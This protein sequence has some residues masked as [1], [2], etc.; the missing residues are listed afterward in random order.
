MAARKRLGLIFTV[1]RKWMG[2]T[3]YVLN[4]IYALSTLPDAEK[5]EI[6][7]LCKSEEDYRLAVEYT[8]YPYLSFRKSQKKM[9]TLS[10]ALNKLSRVIFHRNLIPVLRNVRGLDY[11]FP[12]IGPHQIVK[13][14]KNIAW[15]PDFQ[16]IRLPHLFSEKEI[17]HRDRVNNTL[18]NKNLPI[19]FSS[20]DAKHD[21]C[22]S[23][24]CDADNPN[25]FLYRFASKP[26]VI[27]PAADEVLQKYGVQAGGYFI[28]SNQF[29]VH[30]NHAVLFEAVKIL[31]ER[32]LKIKLLCTGNN[33]DYRSREHYS[34]LEEFVNKNGLQDSIKLLGLIDRNEQL[35]L[36]ARSRAVIQPSLFEG[37]NTSVEEAKSLNKLLILSDLAVHKEQCLRNALFF[38]RDDPADLAD[39]IQEVAENEIEVV[40]NEYGKIVKNSAADFVN[41]LSSL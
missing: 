3:Y 13:G 41:I 6:V 1:D 25:L 9:N 23:Y 35:T 38:K 33:V 30:K 5:P 31:K 40:D 8:G 16:H 12:I 26:P 19:V 21:F 27:P 39:K 37:W 32:G 36:M 24:N 15:I 29:W 22:D 34:G 2:G 10:R 14:A 17:L 11:I 18:R 20:N 28:C 4:L 7:L